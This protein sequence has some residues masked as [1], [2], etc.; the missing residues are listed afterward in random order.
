MTPAEETALRKEFTM[1]Q[2]ALYHALT[3]SF[4]EHQRHI[5]ESHAPE[6]LTLDLLDK[7]Q[8]QDKLHRTNGKA[9]S[10]VCLFFC[11]LF[12]LVFGGC[13]FPPV[14]LGPAGDC[15]CRD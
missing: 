7:V 11:L 12:F 10:T 4:Q 13:A 3:E 6:Q 15:P 5:I 2:Y 8:Q 9:N 1:A 14:S